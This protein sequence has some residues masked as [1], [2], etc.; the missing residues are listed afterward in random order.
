VG[1]QAGR[2]YLITKRSAKLEPTIKPQWILDELKT[3]WKYQVNKGNAY[4][5]I[6]AVTDILFDMSPRKVD[7]YITT[8]FTK[9]QILAILEMLDDRPSDEQ[10]FKK[11]KKAGKNWVANRKKLEARVNMSLASWIGNELL[12]TMDEAR[13]DKVNLKDRNRLLDWLKLKKY[14]EV[15]RYVMRLND[16]EYKRLMDLVYQ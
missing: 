7:A 1:K 3:N 2:Y 14:T 15:L 13:E 16:R 12:P 5:Q 11:L 8:F 6:D 4:R 10:I 9:A